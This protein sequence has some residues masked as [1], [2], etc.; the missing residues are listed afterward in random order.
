VLRKTDS[1]NGTDGG[2][3]IGEAWH[4]FRQEGES[5]WKSRFPEEVLKR[6]AGSMTSHAAAGQLQQRPTA[7]EGG[8]FKREWFS[9]PVKFAPDFSPALSAVNCS[10]AWSSDFWCPQ[11]VSPRRPGVCRQIITSRAASGAR[12]GDRWFSITRPQGGLWLQ[13]MVEDVPTILPLL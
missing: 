1:S 5:L 3:K 4:D 10:W 9:N 11:P 8:L 6:W 2:P 7:R 12:Q 13:S